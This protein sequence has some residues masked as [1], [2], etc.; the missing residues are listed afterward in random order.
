[1]APRERAAPENRPLQDQASP[2]PPPPASSIEPSRP[3][4]ERPNARP[5][6]TENTAAA[7]ELA[8]AYLAYWSAPNALTLDATPDFYAAQVLFHG[9]QM[10]ARALFE[11]KR[12]FVRRWPVRDYRPR[13]ETMRTT[14]DPA[15]PICTVRTVF[16]FSASNPQTGRRSQGTSLLQLGVSFADGEPRIV[17]ETSQVTSRIPSARSEAFEDDADDQ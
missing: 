7:E 15:P 14:C 3:R 9:R 13:R 1:M 5:R 4:P 2:A 12:R 6:E 16:D 11:E 17:F 8:T 10:G